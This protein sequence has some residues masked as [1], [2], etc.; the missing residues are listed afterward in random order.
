MAYRRRRQNR[1]YYTVVGVSLVLIL[2]L[3]VVLIIKLKDNKVETQETEAEVEG[4]LN[5]DFTLSEDDYL[6]TE[7]ESAETFETENNQTDDTILIE[8]EATDSLPEIN[9]SSKG[10]EIVTPQPTKTDP[11]ATAATTTAAST[12]APTPAPTPGSDLLEEITLPLGF[13]HISADKENYVNADGSN[14]MYQGDYSGS[15]TYKQQ[16]I[17]K[18][19]VNDATKNKINQIVKLSKEGT[20]DLYGN[21]AGNKL[22][23]LSDSYPLTGNGTFSANLSPVKGV[24][25]YKSVSPVIQGGTASL[26]IYYL[27]EN[28]ISYVYSESY[29]ADL[30]KPSTLAWFEIRGQLYPD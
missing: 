18:L 28:M 16:N 9:E 6:A 19:T 20:Q 5:I 24:T 25:E 4:S 11:P 3:T 21:L 10:P 23:L 12:K 30:V 14:E 7:T 13:G 17:D 22:S 26:R 8:T 2:V 15:I 29:Q 1:M 27:A